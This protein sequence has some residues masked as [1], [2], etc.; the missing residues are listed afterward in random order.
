MKRHSPAE[1]DEHYGRIEWE[2]ERI[3]ELIERLLIFARVESGAAEVKRE[4]VDLKALLREIAED[5]DFEAGSQDKAVRIVE[6]EACTTNGVRE[7]LFSAIENVVRNAVH[8][9][10]EGTEVE[11][12]MRCQR[13][14]EQVSLVVVT[15]RDY[16]PGVPENVLPKLFRPFYRV[17][18]STGDEEGGVGLGL[19]IAQKAVLAH[20]GT[21]RA[22]N[23]PGGG[24]IVEIAIPTTTSFIPCSVTTRRYNRYRDSHLA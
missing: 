20:G 16:G 17:K 1:S 8:Y 12:G 4:D 9:T 10:A 2:I 5:A 23:A 14:N 7:F 19:A 11:I 15:V 13:H 6:S 18:G 3:D 24:L 21:I 22:M